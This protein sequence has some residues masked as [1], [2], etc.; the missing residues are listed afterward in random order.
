MLFKVGCPPVWGPNIVENTEICIEF[1]DLMHVS[2]LFL[3]GLLVPGFWHELIDIVSEIG[4]RHRQPCLSLAVDLSIIVFSA[5]LSSIWVFK[6]GFPTAWSWA[7]LTKIN[8]DMH[9]LTHGVS[10]DYHPSLLLYLPVNSI[11]KTRIKVRVSWTGLINS[12]AGV[13]TKFSQ[14]LN[15]NSG[16][17][18]KSK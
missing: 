2:A 17:D 11:S 12:Q 15:N 3:T 9:T 6:F 13:I 8:I 18:D 16:E 10:I 1:A 14:H 5:F 4:A 7:T